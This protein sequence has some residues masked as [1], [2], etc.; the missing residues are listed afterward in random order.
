MLLLSRFSFCF[1][2]RILFRLNFAVFFLSEFVVVV[3][4]AYSEVYVYICSMWFPM[5]CEFRSCTS[6]DHIRNTH[7]I[8]NNIHDNRTLHS[9]QQLGKETLLGGISQYFL[10][11]CKWTGKSVG[12]KM[13]LTTQISVCNCLHGRF[14]CCWCLWMIYYCTNR[15]SFTLFLFT[16]SR[17]TTTHKARVNQ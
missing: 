13:S 14:I 10:H 8:N 9:E 4:V 17:I 11:L 12:S 16:E 7:T 6:L 3:V 15:R 1:I 2:C 5:F